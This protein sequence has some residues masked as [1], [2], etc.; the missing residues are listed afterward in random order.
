MKN[1]NS[2]LLG[3]KEMQITGTEFL[4]KGTAS[5]LN[6]LDLTAWES[7]VNCLEGVW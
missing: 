2:F 7:R 3:T 1:D 4:V 6:R 5:L